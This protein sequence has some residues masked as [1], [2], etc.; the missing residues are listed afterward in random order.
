MRNLFCV[1][2]FLVIG[3]YCFSQTH[4]PKT[5]SI[6][7]NCN[8]Y[9]EYLPVNYATSGKQYP[10]LVYCGGAGTF[11][12]GTTS[13]LS[14]LLAEGPPYYINN[15]Q[16]PTTFT[17]ATEITSFIVIS[18]QF[19]AWPKPADVEA[20]LN[21]VLSHGYRV[22]QSRIYLA[23]F[24]AGGDVSW[25][26]PNTGILSA[27]KLAALVP[28]SG[29]NYPYVDSGAKYISA[30]NL[31]VWALH[32][33]SDQTAPYTWSQNFVNKI[34]SFNPSV[35]AKIT[36]V[37]GPTH[38][39][40]KNYFYN[41]SFRDGG[42]NVYEWMLQYRRNY[43][44]V[45][46]AGTDLT[47]TLP[48]SSV[49]LDGTASY[50]PEN[51]PLTYSWTKIS[52][53]S[54]YT[55]DNSSSASPLVSGLVA[56]TYSF[57]LTVSDTNGYTGKDTVDIKVIN[58]NPNT[59]P[60]ASAGNDISILLPQTS[61]T[62]N[63][64]SSYDQGGSIESYDW[65]E[66]SG[67]VQVS[68]AK[69]ATPTI[70]NLTKGTYLIKLVVTDNEGGTD[71]DTMK[72]TVINPFPNKAPVSDAG[73]DQTISLP[74]NSVS[75]DGSASSDVD[76]TIVSY[77]WQ[78]IAGPSPAII[79]APNLAM[80]SVTNLVQG[81][82]KFELKVTDDSSAVGKDTIQ[83]IVFPAPTISNRY[84]RVNLYGGTN[85]YNQDGWNNWN[86]TGSTNIT[87]SNF[88][89][90]D[91]AIS[92]INAV[93]SY[94]QGIGDNGASYGGTMCP[95]QVLRYAT[96][97]TASTR[98]LTIKG[99]NN[100]LTYDLE[101]YSSRLT[102]GN[103]TAIVVNG[104]KQTVVTDNN[105]SNSM[106]FTDVKPSNGQIVVSINKSAGTY[107][108]L[109][110]FTLI[111]KTVQQNT[112][113]PPVASAGADIA[114]Q[115]PVNSVQLDGSSSFDADGSIVMYKWSEVSGPASFTISN[116]S[117]ATTSV[118]NLTAGIYNFE[119][120]V[121]D[122][123][124]STSK[125]TVQI[126][127]N[128]IIQPGTADSL[129][130]GRAYTIVML[131]SST[132][133][134]TGAT[135]IDSSW[136]NRYSYYTHNKNLQTTIVNLGVPSL[137][138]YE[139]LCPTGFVPPANRPAPDTLHNISK[140][141]RYRP[142][143]IVINLPSNDIAMGY[144]LQEIKDNYERVMQIADSAQIPVWVT[145][146][147]PR[148]TLSPT[149]RTYQMQLRDWTY[150]RFA[151]KAIDFWTTVANDDGT[152]NPLYSAGDGVH[153]N[154]A[155]HYL[156]YVRVMAERILDSLCLRKNLRPVAKAGNDVVLTLPEDSVQLNGMNSFDSDGGI[157]SYSWAMISGPAQ[158]LTNALA[159]SSPK[160][161]GLIVGTYRFELTVTDN[162]GAI[163]KDTV[164]ITVNPLGPQSPVANAGSDQVI[165]L[166]SNSVQLNANASY[167]PDGTVE[168]YL[169]NK[170][171]GPVSFSITDNTVVNPVI[172]NLANGIYSFQLIVTDNDGLEGKDTL[173]IKVNRPPVANAGN[174]NSIT[175]PVNSLQLDGS[176]SGDADGT[177]IAFKWSKVSGPSQYL[178]SNSFVVKPTLSNLAQGTYQFELTVTDNDGASAKDTVTIV[179]NHALNLAPVANAGTDQTITLPTSAA[180]VNGS[181]S[182]DSDGSIVN[183]QWSQISGPSSATINSSSSVSSQINNLIEGIYL[184]ELKVTDD[185]SAIGK[186]T[187]Q[188]TVLPQP[189]TV[190]KL[191]RVNVYG[192]ANP[193]GTGNWNNWTIGS[194]ER[195]NSA[196]ANFIYDDATVSTINANLS[197]S[198]GI[199][200][201]GATYGGT[202]C[203]P[204]VL[205]Y[206]SYSTST[207]TLI[208]KGLNNG[209]NYDIEFYS[210]RA[211]TGNSTQFT[212]N[213][214]SKTVVTDK[215]LTNQVVFT[216][217]VPANGQI[218]ITL[219]RVGTYN[220]LNGFTLT[221]R[222]QL[223]SPTTNRE[224]SGM[225][226]ISEKNDAIN[227]FPNPFI[228]Q[229]QLTL[230]D[231]YKGIF[232]IQIFDLS[233]RLLKQFEFVKTNV[234]FS[235]TLSMQ[236]LDKGNYILK[237]QIGK[238]KYSTKLIKLK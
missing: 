39:G 22:D 136:V 212:I 191:I 217:L 57:E 35:R 139:V 147:Q 183:Y 157:V 24:S 221:E 96:Y 207:R 38:D 98:S 176:G 146:T 51:S 123:S 117:S 222:A 68:I 105:K 211:N 125:D 151:N 37:S 84:V 199:A 182:F 186:D 58:P 103:S 189:T 72:L 29:Y 66:L 81:T 41:P 9:Y 90:S 114:L 214:A 218:A 141:L 80:T 129:N 185:S 164:Q 165:N 101:F 2:T 12:S 206:A 231:S 179:V 99:L 142:D 226:T 237:M 219:A 143:A 4:T 49:R 195:S 61:V 232:D 25:K 5:V 73:T 128:E 209:Y 10:L 198:S 167:D 53:P 62:L 173:L 228:S 116:P 56:G 126:T 85:P 47:I 3:S 124:G 168:S 13:Q 154:N 159:S 92:S 131:G 8:G 132:T 70:N 6:T 184:F 14:K 112:S 11:G 202:M 200:D 127:V 54:P 93:L 196:S 201:N 137:T 144:S 20:V 75:L 95:A 181:S 120:A 23:G 102:T 36:L 204:P 91:G 33:T 28:V 150:Q 16:F 192:G 172:T 190:S 223:S 188:I 230:N 122:N 17:T 160:I 64:S 63:A 50:D 67:P 215:N 46:K 104:V 156:F 30:A 79:V 235:K 197:F 7:S 110:G 109:N 233:G 111:E 82:Y 27:K 115:L 65:T 48:V 32:S 34:N 166:P 45:A 238:N 225:P 133:Y 87:S 138:S 86:V 55:I 224:R 71:A 26:Y 158:F 31:P 145:T 140:A 130:C 229:V 149:E 42:Y 76:G 180:V 108:Y 106:A 83:V 21:Y 213:G 152:I 169:W 193:Y 118:T 187:V 134:G 175:L 88:K 69:S 171:S 210:S 135:P 74:S 19:V 227:V 52:G 216:N 163:G 100:S 234:D 15:K 153:V 170:I 203:P 121:T 77:L 78:Q 148:N 94:T 205:R 43:P 119:L 97:S 155:G 162:L 236:D 113:A 1:V 89:Y 60:V 178:L 220:Y 174:D 161:K 44:P 177:I 18:P 208:I 194:G 59:L 40:S 107:S